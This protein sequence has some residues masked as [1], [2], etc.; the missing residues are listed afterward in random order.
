M[1]GEVLTRTVFSTSRAAE[2]V[3]KRALQTQT[4]QHYRYFGDVVVKE[5][6]DNALDAAEDA[7]LAPEIEVT[8]EVDGHLLRVTVSDNG[9]GIPADVVARILDFNV[10]ASSNAAYR[11]P[12][13]GAQGNALK[14]VLGIP[15]AL[16]VGAPVVIEA[17]GL[18]HEITVWLDPAGQVDWRHI[19]TE[20]SRTVGT[21]VM[22]PLP[23]DQGVN[24]SRW[25]Q[26]FAVVNPH[27]TFVYLADCDGDS[28]LEVYKSAGQDACGKV[29]SNSPTSPHWYDEAALKKLVFAHIGDH[30]AGG[31]DKPLGLFLK[32]FEGLSGTAKQRRIRRA[33]PQVQ[34]LSDFAEEPDGVGALL[35]AM[36]TEARPPNPTKLGEVHEDHYRAR[37][38]EAFGVID[39]R[40]WFKRKRWA[41]DNVPWLLEVGVAETHKPGEIV[42]AINYGAAFDDP[43]GKTILDHEDICTTGVQPFLSQ[44]NAAPWSTNDRL[45]AVVVHVVSPAL[46]FVE[47]S[48]TSLTVPPSVAIELG[49]LL[50]A[51]TKVLRAEKKRAEKDRLA[52]KKRQEKQCRAKPKVSLL[53]AVFE[54]LPEAIAE[55]SNYGKLPFPTRNLYY[56]VRPRIQRLTSEELQMGYFS[57][58]LV[59]SWEKQN[60]P[61]PG[62]YRD[63]RGE[64]REPHTKAVVRL[65][66]REV[67]GYQLPKYVYNKIL[68]V[69]KEGLNPI[70]EAAKLAERYDL[71]IASGKGQPVEAVRALF[72]RAA[73]DFQLF[74]LHDADPAGYMIAKT[75]SENTPRMPNYS[76]DVI[77]LGL[78]VAQAVERELPT[79]RFTRKNR[80]PDW[81]PDRLDEQETEWFV[82]HLLTQPW[83]SNK[84]WEGTRVELNALG[85]SGLIDLIE[86][87]LEVHGATAKV[88]PPHSNV[89]AAARDE[90]RKALRDLVDEVLAERLDLDA[91]VETM[92][93]ET[94]HI[95]EAD[96]E[97]VRPLLYDDGQPRALPWS[98]A[99]TNLVT[100]RLGELDAGDLR[101]RIRTLLT[102]NLGGAA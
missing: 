46:E 47:K 52:E 14:T 7:T 20:S 27:A 35:E 55:A 99:V 76:V 65:G 80:L 92:I 58:T 10:L 32:E 54:V 42:W 48:K 6:I 36:Q 41:V 38:D 64:L 13:R 26:K 33:L 89:R 31:E 17:R 75:I 61:I 15:C 100:D 74:V 19:T 57:Q 93:D 67:N 68:Y 37:L 12:T 30:R 28:T 16:G 62:H 21:A 8:S 56:S 69:E 45:R 102:E 94:A 53:D 73:G 79:E 22:V 2:F 101:Q 43:F 72:E 83:D 97:T 49:K 24:V 82:G 11:S 25:V 39:D 86:T 66:T 23:V 9:N 59:V 87:E 78:K 1:T 70:F 34:H 63:P 51:T 81:M 85:S 40:W 84:Q 18:R 50:G 71:A 88:I 96:R 3:D 77:D 60:G 44:C 95:G 5:L 4:G 90:H 29:K 91:V 98:E